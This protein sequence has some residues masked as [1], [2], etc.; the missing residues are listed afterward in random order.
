MDDARPVNGNGNGNGTKDSVA[1]L[2]SGV[3][4]SLG[5]L[6]LT[7]Y[8]KEV[9]RLDLG[10]AGL[11]ARAVQDAETRG[12]QLEFVENTKARL[13]FL[14]EDLTKLDDRLQREMRD[15][16]KIAE[17]KLNALDIR[18]Q[19]EI[20]RNATE[21]HEQLGTLKQAVDVLS[22][23]QTEAAGIHAGQNA[24]LDALERKP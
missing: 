19:G 6:A 9:T 4:L 10:I 15:L 22:R 12:R 20:T 17:G 18:L 3:L 13:L 8:A 23:F 5:G 21:R 14:T 16:D 24:R 2:F 1:R 11:H 7:F